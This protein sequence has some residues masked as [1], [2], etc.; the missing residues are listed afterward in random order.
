MEKAGR[1]KHQL[2]DIWMGSVAGE[3]GHDRRWRSAELYF[4]SDPWFYEE[5][6]S[7]PSRESMLSRE[8]KP[9]FLEKPGKLLLKVGFAVED[10]AGQGKDLAQAR[11]GGR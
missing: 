1:H 2:G 6:D 7:I 10:E 3:L 5:V 11:G 8:R 4:E 9:G